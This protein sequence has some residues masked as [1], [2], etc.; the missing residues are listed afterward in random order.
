MIL[1]V[2]SFWL[3]KNEARDSALHWQ[4]SVERSSLGNRNNTMTTH[5]IPGLLSVGCILMGVFG[6]SFI[7]WGV[8]RKHRGSI[9][10][11]VMIMALEFPI[12]VGLLSH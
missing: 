5:T 9:A 11:G 12:R 7:V 6:F 4:M 1:P 10:A 8:N 3:N 2:S